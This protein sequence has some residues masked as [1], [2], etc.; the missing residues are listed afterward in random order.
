M[1]LCIFALLF[2]LY[3]FTYNGFEKKYKYVNT[4]VIN[5][6]PKFINK[7]EKKETINTNIYELETLK[8]K[9]DIELIPGEPAPFI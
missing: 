4:S 3:V 6:D 7:I 8:S 2:D 9:K 5:Y 1:L